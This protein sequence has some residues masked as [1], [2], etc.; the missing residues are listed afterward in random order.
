MLYNKF[1]TSDIL[2]IIAAII[3]G[4]LAIYVIYTTVIDKEYNII[5]ITGIVI[6]VTIVIS[7]YGSELYRYHSWSK[8]EIVDITEE[9]NSYR[10]DYVKNNSQLIHS[11]YLVAPDIRYMN[12]INDLGY[13]PVKQ[14][15]VKNYNKDVLYEVKEKNSNKSISI[16]AIDYLD[17]NTICITYA[18]LDGCICQDTEFSVSYSVDDYNTWIDIRFNEA[19]LPYSLIKQG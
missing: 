6:M 9:G 1:P 18:D 14:K 15:I 7:H 10:I 5:F 13:D 2:I 8:R 4:C 17:D 19:V 12:D 3:I 11:L 16:Y